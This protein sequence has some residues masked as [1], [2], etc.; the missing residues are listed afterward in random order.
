MPHAVHGQ[1]RCSLALTKQRVILTC[2][3]CEKA[4]LRVPNRHAINAKITRLSRVSD[5]PGVM[6]VQGAERGSKATRKPL[7][8]GVKK[9][10]VAGNGGVNPTF[11][12]DAKPKQVYI[13]QESLFNWR[14]PSRHQSGADSISGCCHSILS[15][16]PST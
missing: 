16:A 1:T 5:S 9:Y 7:I 13:K 6:R 3:R 11:R 10:T 4:A 15:V 14:G 12:L 2:D 8:I